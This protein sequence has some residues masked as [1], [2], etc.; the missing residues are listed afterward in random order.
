MPLDTIGS[1]FFLGRDAAVEGMPDFG[2]TADRPLNRRCLAA[3]LGLRLLVRA[4]FSRSES[5]SFSSAMGV[6]EETRLDAA[7][8][9]MGAK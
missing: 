9:V 8:R 1:G 7:E 4:R 5:E 6:G 3:V 2:V